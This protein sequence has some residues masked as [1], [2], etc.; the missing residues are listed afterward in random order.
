MLLLAR[1]SS[2]VE[3]AAEIRADR[4]RRTEN[5][6]AR[7]P[8]GQAFDRQGLRDDF[9]EEEQSRPITSRQQVLQPGPCKPVQAPFQRR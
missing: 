5:N 9:V 3:T 2:T 1:L 7:T 8:P 4:E 6:P